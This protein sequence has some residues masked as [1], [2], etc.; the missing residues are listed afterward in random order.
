MTFARENNI[1]VST[2]RGWIYRGNSSS[3]VEQ[4]PLA[5]VTLES[6]PV[7]LDRP[8][9]VRIQ[10]GES[11]QVW[12]PVALSDEQAKRWLRLLEVL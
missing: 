12:L 8:G 10:C 11:T 1:N 2:L 6:D 4:N 9:T 3:V 5:A 7:R